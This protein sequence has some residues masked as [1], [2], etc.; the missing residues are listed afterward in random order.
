MLLLLLLLRHGVLLLRG[1]EGVGGLLSSL[2][3]GIRLL[4]LHLLLLLGRGQILLLLRR[5]EHGMRWR[6]GVL[7]RS[8]VLTLLWLLHK[9][10]LMRWLSLWKLLLALLWLQLLPLGPATLA[11]T[12]ARR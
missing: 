6:L 10:L 11:R 2:R 7:G 9:H 4:L 3:R 8:R 12:R 5:H 1:S